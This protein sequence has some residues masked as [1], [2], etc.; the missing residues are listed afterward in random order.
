MKQGK[1]LAAII[2]VF[3]VSSFKT[4]HEVAPT[5]ANPIMD[6]SKAA[7]AFKVDMEQSKLTWL[8]KKVT[9]E[10]AGTINVSSGSLLIEKNVLKRGSFELDT[11][12]ITVTD[13]TDKTSNSKLLG[14]L[15]SDDFFA[16]NKFGNANL[17]ITS[18][19]NK[20][21]GLYNIKGDKTIY[22]DFELNIQLVA[23]K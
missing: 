3:V 23:S 11:K 20:G 8:A 17:V 12:S 2:A 6:V 1:T 16:V 13:I 10:H 9:G 19:K 21:G 14:H 5:A 4:V 18:A 22:D 7:T 15:K